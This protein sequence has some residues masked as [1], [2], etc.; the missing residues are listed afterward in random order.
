MPK[1]AALRHKVRFV[2]KH[3]HVQ[4]HTHMQC[5]IMSGTLGP[6]HYLLL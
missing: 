6:P 3:K 5:N 4:M 1:A 2:H